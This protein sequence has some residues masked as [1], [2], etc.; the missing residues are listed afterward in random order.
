M[1]I[2]MD[3]L[4]PAEMQQ[5]VL[6]LGML[7]PDQIAGAA[8]RRRDLRAS[9]PASA[10]PLG[11][12][13]ALLN[14]FRPWFAAIT[15]VQLQLM[16]MGL[17]PDSGVETAPDARARGR[18][19]S[20]SRAWRRCASSWRCWR[21][22]RTSSSANSCCTASRTPSARRREIDE[23]LAPGGAATQTALAKLLQEGFDEYPDLYRP[24][25]VERNRKWIPQIEELL[26][27]AGRLPGRR[28]RAAPGRHGQRH[29]PAGAQGLQGEAAL[30]R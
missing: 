3:D 7:P 27:D 26:D 10:R 21:A 1:E 12:D 8:A 14:R 24:L 19:Q 4:D 6:E 25:T 30:M 11:V 20:R 22:C 15:L 13:P 18:R 5:D 28:R 23:L 16:K 2:D 9:S 17:D 29:R